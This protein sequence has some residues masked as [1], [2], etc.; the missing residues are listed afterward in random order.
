MRKADKFSK[1]VNYCNDSG[2]TRKLEC[3]IYFEKERKFALIGNNSLTIK[4][5]TIICRVRSIISLYKMNLS[6]LVTEREVINGIL[7]ANNPNEHCL[8]Y[9]RQIQNINI[10]QTSTASKF[11]DIVHK[12]VSF[13]NYDLI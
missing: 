4:C 2:G 3:K 10:N 1:K 7:Q 11:I 9:V 13:I 6:N 8:C 12:Q 5:I